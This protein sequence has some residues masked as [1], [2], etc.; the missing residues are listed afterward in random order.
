MLAF[1]WLY[2]F[3][4]APLPSCPVTGFI[5]FQYNCCGERDMLFSAQCFFGVSRITTQPCAMFFSC[6]N[7]AACLPTDFFA[8]SEVRLFHGILFTSHLPALTLCKR[9]P[10]RVAPAALFDLRF[11]RFF[12]QT[13]A[14][15]VIFS[16]QRSFC[17]CY[18]L[19]VS[20]S[21]HSSII[22]IIRCYYRCLHMWQH[23]VCME[24]CETHGLGLSDL[25]VYIPAVRFASS[26][27]VQPTAAE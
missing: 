4:I 12:R 15:V 8:R 20:V 11:P 1:S 5:L 23:M 7:L 24:M 2:P 10:E 22:A 6:E 25:R 16:G 19:S 26:R 3:C 27:Q 21:I 9:L 13:L 17:H 14:F 18:L